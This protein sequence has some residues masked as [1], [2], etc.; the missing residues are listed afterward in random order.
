MGDDD[1]NNLMIKTMR[2][3]TCTMMVVT[4]FLLESAHAGQ[5]CSEE[6]ALKAAFP[7]AD[8]FKK[9]VAVMTRE[10]H[11]KIRQLPNSKNASRIF[12]YTIVAKQGRFLGYAIVDTALGK[13][14]PITFMI[15]LSPNLTVRKVQILAHPKSPGRAIL[16]KGFLSQFKGKGV[17]DKVRV[18][19][20][21][22]AVTGATISSRAT[23]DVV[24]RVLARF[25][26][27]VPGVPARSI[28][29]AASGKKARFKYNQ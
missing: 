22:D 21:I 18:G 14:V 2:V 20:D 5:I 12:K 4:I 15:A 23:T 17:T 10:Q 9:K 26:I 8:F 27:L 25:S 3:A 7:E 13:S 6:N 29:L 1:M 19:R 11:K 28:K 16:Q 24:R